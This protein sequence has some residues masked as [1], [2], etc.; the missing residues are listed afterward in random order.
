MWGQQ[1]GFSLIEMMIVLAIVGILSAMAFPIYKGTILKIRRTEAKVA[2][3][4]LATK[5]EHYYLYHHSR[6]SEVSLQKLG[7][8]N[9]T[10]HHYYKLLINASDDH[11]ELIAI[12]TFKDEA[13]TQLSLNELGEKK[14][15]GSAKV[16]W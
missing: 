10:E 5:M 6:Y 2:L 13:C 16:C 15:A 11:Y 12:P 4:N 8:M 1:S 9:K 3:L 7:V 14:S